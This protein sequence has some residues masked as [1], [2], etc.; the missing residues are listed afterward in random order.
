MLAGDIDSIGCAV[1]CCIGY[2]FELVPFTDGIA[3]IGERV[4][5]DKA[6]PLAFVFANNPEAGILGMSPLVG[7]DD[8]EC[9]VRVLH[10]DL[11]DG[12]ANAI[13]AAVVSSEGEIVML[14]ITAAHPQ[15][16]VTL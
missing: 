2:Y 3:R 11:V 1:A 7:V 15:D 16:A 6:G 12:I 4:E 10:L 13:V 8:E 14:A 5:R 9:L